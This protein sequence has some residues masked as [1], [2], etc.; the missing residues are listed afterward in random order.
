MLLLKL[1]PAVDLEIDERGA[2][3]SFLGESATGRAMILAWILRLAGYLWHSPALAPMQT[4]CTRPH[5]SGIW[6]TLP[7]SNRRHPAC[8]AGA[9]PSEL[10]ARDLLT[11]PPRRHPP[12]TVPGK[13]GAPSKK[14]EFGAG[15]RSDPEC[16]HI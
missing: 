16:A 15:S 5:H 7:G 13:G 4:L 2:T 14:H 6:W 8:K 3:A 1:N 9:L 12:L 10:K 11:K